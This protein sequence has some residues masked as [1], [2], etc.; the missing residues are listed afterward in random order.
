M[1]INLTRFRLGHASTPIDRLL[2]ILKLRVLRGRASLPPP[3]PYRSLSG[4]LSGFAASFACLIH[5]S[6]AAS[7]CSSDA[8]RC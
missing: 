2:K 4:R 7:L 6:T 8:T 5:A 3:A 1:V